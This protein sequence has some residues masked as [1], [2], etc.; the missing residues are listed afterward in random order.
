MLTK[1]QYPHVI[2]NVAMTA[3]GKTDTLH[4]RGATISSIEDKQ[5]VDH[6]RADVDAIMV[7][8]HTLMSDDP[9]LT[10][11]SGQL[12]QER[13]DRGLSANPIKVGVVTKAAIQPDSRFLTDGPAQV[14]LFTTSQTEPTQVELLRQQGVLVYVLGEQQVDLAL[15]LQKLGE[16]GVQRLLVEGGGIL[17][18]FLLRLQLI[19]EINIYIAP[20]IFGGASAPT[21]VNGQGFSLDEAL[22]LQLIAINKLGDAGVLLHYLPVYGSKI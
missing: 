21:F 22:R 11:K 13:L 6:L 19:D 3:D 16:M 2:L 18:E 9:R 4:R 10:V 5:R 12:R 8:G 20:L 17:I 7:G 14:I 1:I 15:A